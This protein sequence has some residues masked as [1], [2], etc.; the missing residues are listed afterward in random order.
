MEFKERL[1]KLRTKHGLTQEAL[2]RKIFVSRSAI[3]K[4][5]AGLGMPNEESIEALC[6]V[7]GA[8]R[9]E[10][11]PNSV[12]EPLLVEKN[13]KLKRRAVIAIVL[14]ITLFISLTAL[15]V[16]AI[17]T[18]REKKEIFALTPTLTKFYFER[19]AFFSH[20]GPLIHRLQI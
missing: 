2:A 3:A 4:W 14:A 10:L 12:A 15:A 9:Q 13:V 8:D 7:L 1:K 19:V 16:I 17:K 11:L 6:Q 5:E 18:H 20:R